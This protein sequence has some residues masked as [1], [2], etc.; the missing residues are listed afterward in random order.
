ML[1]LYST[2]LCIAVHPKCFTIM[3]G[4]PLNHHQCLYNII[5]YERPKIFTYM[6]GRGGNILHLLLVCHFENGNKSERLQPMTDHIYKVTLWIKNK[7]KVIIISGC[8]SSNYSILLQ[9][10]C[11]YNL[12]V[13]NHNATN[14]NVQQKWHYQWIRSFLLTKTIIYDFVDRVFCMENKAQA[15]CLTPQK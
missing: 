9:K 13:T 2:L 4:G 11:C 12:R 3:G 7:L 10:L 1:H 15:F 5:Y 8:G 6:A 14:V